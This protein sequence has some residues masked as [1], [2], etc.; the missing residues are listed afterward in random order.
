MGVPCLIT[1]WTAY[2]AELR[3]F[4][5]HRSG[6]AEEADDLLQEVFIRAL[7]QDSQFCSIEN[8]RAW[9]FQV[10]R[11]I[12]ADRFRHAH[13]HVSLP[14]DIPE[15]SRDE[16]PAVDSLSQCLPR[17]L[18]ELSADDRLAITFCDIEGNS[19]QALAEH[20]GISLPGAKSRIQRAR[21]RL[22]EQLVCACQVTFDD[23][24]DVCCFVPRPPLTGSADT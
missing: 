10:A 16:A 5:R 18:S 19:Q 4:I 24:G 15:V 9:L 12:L 20:L 2:E 17:V 22:R 14:D 21:Q 3:G 1:A 6:L 13:E 11:N 8:P 23:K 7:R